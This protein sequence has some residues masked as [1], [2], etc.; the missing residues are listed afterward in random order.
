MPRHAPLPVA[1]RAQWRRVVPGR[2]GAAHGARRRGARTLGQLRAGML[3][4]LVLLSGDITE[5]PPEAI[6]EMQVAL[7][8]CNGRIVYEV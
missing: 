8:L 4:D 3:A 1:E 7:T 5:V 6:K 2:A